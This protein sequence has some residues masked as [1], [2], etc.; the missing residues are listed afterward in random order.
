[1]L[2]VLA[3]AGSFSSIAQDATAVLK[4]ITVPAETIFVHA[5]A[6]TLLAGETLYCGLYCLDSRRMPSDISKIAYLE[7]VG[8]N[9]KSIIT[10]KVVLETGMAKADFFI[11]TT[12]QTGN[13]K[14]IAYTKRML[15]QSASNFF[16]T[17]LTLINPFTLFEGKTDSILPKN[18]SERYTS[19]PIGLQTDK[20][21]YFHRERVKIN[22]GGTNPKGNYSLSVRKIDDIPSK[23]AHHATE[24]APQFTDAGKINAVPEFRGEMVSGNIV[25]KRA[26]KK[27]AGKMVALSIPG[28][29]FAFKIA[30]TDA[31]GKFN[32]ILD[33]NPAQ[34][35]LVIQVMAEDRNDYRISVNGNL[36]PDL[37]GLLFSEV[38]LSRSLRDVIEQRSVAVQIENAYYE[39]KMDS[40]YVPPLPPPFFHPLEKTYVLDDYTRFPTLRETIIEVLKEVY[41]RKDGDTYSLHLRNM[42][43]DTEV[44]GLPL[45][46]V[47][48]LLVQDINDLFD[49]PAK[50][51][52]S[53]SLVNAPY[54]YGPKTFS[55][56]I[57]FMTKNQDFKS[58]TSGDFITK[59]TFARP[60]PEK[61]YLQ[62]DYSGKKAA[63]RIPDYRQQLL[64]LPDMGSKTG[65]ND[66][67]FFT[68][69]VSGTF[70]IRLEGFSEKGI[71]V[72]ITDFI[73]VE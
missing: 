37:S 16:A 35:G 9:R 13:Y 3:L 63:S 67:S 17:D 44:Y 8:T 22:F 30:Q 58:R 71:P 47:D 64:W 6:S 45:V 28:D 1:M 70:E 39:K 52:E 41:F 23:S 21:T 24:F 48:G 50:N 55:G 59:M 68:S 40:V 57:S 62:P 14:L 65:M 26:E 10:Q 60:L 43:M 72:S 12:L 5:N 66:I 29:S 54:V 46:L 53:A 11:P 36:A 56:I 51:I 49:F 31:D 20:K 4:N 34:S 19:G 15:D 18:Q 33:K 42:T 61:G 2:V 69:D 7:L 38:V 73:Q 32:F 27:I 25:A